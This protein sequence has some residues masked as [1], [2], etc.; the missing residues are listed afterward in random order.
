MTRVLIV[1]TLIALTPVACGGSDAGGDAPGRS[2]PRLPSLLG[3]AAGADGPDVRP[4]WEAV[5]ALRGDGEE[6]TDTFVIADDAI[7]WRASWRCDAGGR[8]VIETL[9]RP[10]GGQALVDRACAGRG[11]AFAVDTGRLRLSVEADGPWRAVLEQQVDTPLVEPA[12][13]EMAPPAKVVARG[14]FFDVEQ[15]GKGKVAIYEL[16]DGR[17]A[18]RLEDFWVTPNIDLELWTSS[19]ARPKTSKQVFNAPHHRI[20]FLKAT[21][22]DHNYV[23][24]SDL[25]W[26]RVRSIAIWCQITHEVYAAASLT[27]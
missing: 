12:L 23:L 24:P 2:Q 1:G 11:E 19:L 20:R 25:P 13:D 16:S 7:Q 14:G 17:L 10:R 15:E 18:V 27:S 21:A 3:D 26:G 4:R 5:R 9:P 6:I 22:G 8:L